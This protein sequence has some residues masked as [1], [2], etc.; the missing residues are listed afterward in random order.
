MSSI[1]FA[2]AIGFPSRSYQP[3]FKEFE[4]RGYTI[5]YIEK[6]GMN[7]KYPI[8]NN[9]PHLV[10]ELADEI[11]SRH[12]EPVIGMG[13]S[14]G[15]LLTYLVARKYPELYSQIIVLDAPTINGLQNIPWWI[16]KRLKLS[17]LVTPAG[18]SKKRRTHF[19]TMEQVQDLHN[20]R[21]LR[22]VQDDCFASYV[23]HGFVPADG[24]GFTLAFPLET[25]LALFRNAPDDLWRY[26]EPLPVRGIYISAEDN[27]FSKLP[28]A[29]RLCKQASMDYSV[30]KGSHMFPQEY[31]RDSAAYIHEW[32]AAAN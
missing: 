9:W 12:S 28:F 29:E 27:E 13:H 2:H 15:G 8:T 14:A 6:I 31:T 5:D 17:D 16:L 22:N 23:E 30:L 18:Q 20:S 11:R 26:K 3:F 4:Q 21:L 19:D 7:P 1:F 25:E 24:G 32:I 10:E